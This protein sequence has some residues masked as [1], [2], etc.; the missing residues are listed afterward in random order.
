MQGAVFGGVG[1][2]TQ[3]PKLLDL[4]RSGNLK[5]DELVTTR[6]R[7][8]DINQ[9]YRDDVRRQ[10][11]SRSDRLLRRRLLNRK[12]DTMQ[13]HDSNYIDG[14]WAVSSGAARIP[15][16]NPANDEVIAEVVAGTAADV[17]AA[18]A[19]ARA[20]FRSLVGDLGR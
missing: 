7:L 10:E 6:Y 5:L 14:K 15:V 16:I 11:P 3:I 17:D 4:Y 9:G 1:P 20:A 19:A 8:E 12:R 2:R 18:V 13:I